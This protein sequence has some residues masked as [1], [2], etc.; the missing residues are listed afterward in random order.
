VGAIGAIWRHP[1]P[2]LRRGDLLETYAMPIAMPLKPALRCGG[3]IGLCL[4]AAALAAG[5]S[6]PAGAARPDL[7]VAVQ[8][9]FD[10]LERHDH[11]RWERSSGWSNGRGFGC[12][13]RGDNVRFEHGAMTLVLVD[14]PGRDH[15]LSCGEYRTHDHYH[16]GRYEV[17]MRA[18]RGSGVISAFF[19]YTG[20]PFKTAWHETTIEILGRDTTQV[21][22]TYF[23][24]GEPHSTTIDLGFDAAED[25]HTYAI[26]W[27]PEAISWYV[28]GELKHVDRAEDGP[29]PSLPGRIFAHMWNNEGLTEWAGPFRYAGEPITAA[30]QW[31]RYTPRGAAE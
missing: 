29:L 5:A 18:A 14:T 12:S 10:P 21:Q 7:K 23:I 3:L 27:Q 25:F 17:S 22:F 16:Y 30:Y 11:R 1:P 15:R 9:F 2:S 24:D 28:D 4:G 6:L 26:D 19:L 13:W 8:G 31:I 20:S